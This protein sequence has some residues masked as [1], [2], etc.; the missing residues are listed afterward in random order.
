[1]WWI[2][3][4]KITWMWCYIRWLMLCCYKFKN[5]IFVIKNNISFEIEINIGS[6]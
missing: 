3:K 4:H 2:N 1:M 5:V 6:K